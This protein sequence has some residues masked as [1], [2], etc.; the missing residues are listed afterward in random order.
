MIAKFHCPNFSRF[1]ENVEKRVKS[2]E[3][4]LGFKYKVYKNKTNKKKPT[5]T[6]TEMIILSFYKHQLSAY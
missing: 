4:I 1:L 3:D 5:W 6:K 2:S